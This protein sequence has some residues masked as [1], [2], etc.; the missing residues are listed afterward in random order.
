MVQLTIMGEF[1]AKSRTAMDLLYHLST[2]NLAEFRLMD[3]GAW[4]AAGILPFIWRTASS[5]RTLVLK[6]TRV[7]A[8]ELL[9][10]LRATPAIDTLVLSELIPNSITNLVMEALTPQPGGQ[11][12]LPALT[13][14][15]ISVVY[16]F[17]TNTL[18]LILEGRTS[19]FVVVDIALHRREVHRADFVHFAALRT[20]F[21]FLSLRCLDEARRRVH[22]SAGID[23]HLSN[24]VNET[25]TGR[26]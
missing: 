15:T 17:S 13:R 8:G 2:P 25:A 12:A 14:L 21:E 20:A 9:D 5:L 24:A 1:F 26:D 4:D 18:L 3:C 16:L 6:N 19:S 11:V 10:L 23:P 22:V 7:R